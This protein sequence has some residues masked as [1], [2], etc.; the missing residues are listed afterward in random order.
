MS[1]KTS[2]AVSSSIDP[3]QD[4]SAYVAD[5]RRAAH[6]AVD[7]VAEYLAD[8]RRYPVLAKIKPG[9]LV[10]ALP[11]SGPDK[12]EP[13]DAI[14]REFDQK[15]IPA[16]THWNHPGFLA[17]FG[18]TGSSPVIIAEMLAAALN[19]NGLHWD[20]SPA[21]AELEQ[22]SLG[23]LR[24]WMGL[25]EDWFGIIYD[26]A[27][28]SSF[29]AICA[30][31]EMVAPECRVEGSAPNLVLY[32]SEQSHSS[33]EKGAIAAGIG[34]KHVRK[35]ATDSE[36]R[37]R[38]DLLAKAIEDDWN[39]GLR[40]FCVVATIGTTSSTSIDP[41]AKIAEITD[42]HKLWL[43]VDAAYAGSAA[44]LPEYQWMLKGI[45]RA[46]SYV[47]NPHKWLFTNID[48]SAFYTK[49]P[50]I[51]RRAFSLVPEYLTG[52]EDPRAI[53][54]MDYGVP[55]GHRFRSLKLWFLLR[56][57]GR[58]RLQQ[59]LRSHIAWAKKLEQE[60]RRDARFEVVAPAPFSTVCFRFKGSDE[61]NEQVF[62]AVNASGKY[63]I[64]H[65][66]L[67][68]RYVL[69]IAIGNLGTTWADV[70]GCWR[71]IQEAVASNQ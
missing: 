60:I 48:L 8:T 57:F 42:L 15:I 14:L 11:R 34:Q 27:S 16:V 22:V 17:Y 32:T 47:T 71:M 6:E 64:S 68:D 12:A 39:A 35:I 44:I 9:D 23:W 25:P 20:T 58:E 41:L 43:H 19:T 45:E 50:E 38:P 10:D 63:Y 28:V 65:T 4:W 18:C 31:R 33:I 56:Y 21:V 46:H 54:L 29:H 2:E 62:N 30:A 69:R 51:L 37:M 52:T 3:Q 49:H 66:A 36:F 24:Q 55:L 53:N 1:A 7:W 5:F 40:P 61:E 67:N 13:F 70:E 59:I 26:T